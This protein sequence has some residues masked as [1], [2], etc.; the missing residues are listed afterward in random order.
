MPNE[1]GGREDL[2]AVAFLK[3]LN[4]VALRPRAGRSSPRPRS[5][6][7]GRAS[8]GPTYLGGLGFGFKWNMGWMHDTLAYFQ[9]DPIHRR[10]HHHELTFSLVYAFTRELHPAAVATTRSCTARARCSPRCRA[11]AGRSSPTCARC[12]PTCGRTPAR[13][14][15]SWASEFA[16]EQEWSHERSLDWHLLENPEHAGIQSLVRDLNRVYRDEP[17]AVGDRRLR[18]RLLVARAQRRRR[19]TSSRSPRRRGR[20]A[21]RRSSSSCNLSPVPREGYRLGL[22]R[23]RP[24]ARGA[25]TPTRRTTAARDVGNLGGVEAEDD[26]LARPAV[27]GRADAA[28]ARRAVARA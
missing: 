23:V 21:R 19:T 10:Y 16:Q 27:L 24:L 22:P 12:T 3:E 15:C 20:R 14:C 7:R 8:R 4:E 9:Q 5:R 6:P 2:D 13:S 1:F 18:P 25:S 26:R 17:G 28:A 11:T